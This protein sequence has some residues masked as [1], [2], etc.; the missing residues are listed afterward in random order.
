M[1]PDPASKAVVHLTDIIAGA[2]FNFFVKH[3]PSKQMQ[4]GDDYLERALDLFVKNSD[5]FMDTD[6][7]R[8]RSRFK[9]AGKKKHDHQQ[10]NNLLHKL[11]A[12]HDYKSQSKQAYNLTKDLS[13]LRK[14]AAT[15]AIDVADAVVDIAEHDNLLDENDREELHQTIV[16]TVE[17]SPDDSIFGRPDL[18]SSVTGTYFSSV[19]LNA[20]YTS[21]VNVAQMPENVWATPEL[22]ELIA[23]RARHENQ[24]KHLMNRDGNTPVAIV[25]LKH[26]HAG[27]MIC[28][29]LSSV[30]RSSTTRAKG[31]LHRT[32]IGSSNGRT[33]GT[34][35]EAF[36]LTR[37]SLIPLVSHRG[38]WPTP[39]RSSHDDELSRLQKRDFWLVLV[40]YCAPIDIGTLREWTAVT[41]NLAHTNCSHNAYLVRERYLFAGGLPVCKLG[42]EAPGVDQRRQPFLSDAVPA[43]I[44]ATGKADSDAKKID[45]SIRIYAKD[46]QRREV[47]ALKSERNLLRRTQGL[48][49]ILSSELIS[50][51]PV[52][53]QHPSQPSRARQY[54]SHLNCGDRRGFHAH[55]DGEY[56]VLEK[57]EVES[58]RM[59]DTCPYGPVSVYRMQQGTA[60]YLST[61]VS[62]TFGYI[63]SKYA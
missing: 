55:D 43:A 7:E 40:V 16:S 17:S 38:L 18:F 57:V 5:V 32:G 49:E 21:V 59:D 28:C 56:L 62:T 33:P 3:R 42:F 15:L 37:P 60:L 25:I 30:V 34:P 45:S 46:N 9:K 14:M 52:N 48:A 31:R 8:I 22:A 23:S 41:R 44:C 63:G 1:L 11:K 53:L 29:A 26:A 61:G 50:E 36:N 54:S 19:N 6:K 4:A 58:A 51:F 2:T 10:H 35:P 13:N 47:D 27:Q 20:S 39:P 12:S 24:W